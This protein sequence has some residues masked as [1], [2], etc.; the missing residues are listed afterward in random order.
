MT[1]L[2]IIEL[3]KCSPGM[4]TAMGVSVGLTASC[5]HV[6]GHDR[7]EGALGPRPAHARQDRRVGDHGTELRKSTR[8]ARCSRPR[9]ATATSTCS[10]ARRRSSRTVRTPTRSCS[11]AS[12]TKAT[13][14]PTARSCSSCSTRACP[15]SSSRSRCARW[16]CTRRRP[17]C[18]SSTTCA[19]AATACSA[20]AKRRSAD[21]PGREASK[22]TFVMERSG[23]AAMALG[24]IERCMELCIPYAKERV[25]FGKP[26]GEFQLIQLKLAKMEVA[27][28]NV[29]NLVFRVPRVVPGRQAD[30]A[31]GSLRDEALLRGSRQPRSRSKRC[32]SSAAT[33]TWP[34]TRSSSSRVTRRCCRST[35]EP[36]RS[37]SGRSPARCWRRSQLAASASRASIMCRARATPTGFVST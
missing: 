3:C 30:D 22:A 20:R 6:E 26:I 28:L 35:Q 34:S 16:V 2:P 36:T 24:M 32:S 7:A 31:L 9:V 25:Q 33:A 15:A 21:P 1:L 4:V 23:V 27:R 5:D 12:S 10:R 14:P 11:S 17:A 19:S 8:S 37:R 18:C 29:E 13:R